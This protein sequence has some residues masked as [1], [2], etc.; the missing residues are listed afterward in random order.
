MGL[1]NRNLFIYLFLAL[2]AEG[3]SVE[4]LQVLI[5]NSNARR[6]EVGASGLFGNETG[7]PQSSSQEPLS[8][9]GDA[10]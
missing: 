10:A 9:G 7:Q 5:S 2:V 8:D 3:I 6:F 1:L 4:N